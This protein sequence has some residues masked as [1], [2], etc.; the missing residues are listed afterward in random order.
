MRWSYFVKQSKIG[1][2]LIRLSIPIRCFHHSDIP[3]S[4]NKS[5][6]PQWIV[7]TSLWRTGICIGDRRLHIECPDIPI[8]KRAR[9]VTTITLMNRLYRIHSGV[10]QSRIPNHLLVIRPL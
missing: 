10:E 7:K 4:S 5:A 9:A 8:S 6:P 3:P 2:A 1:S